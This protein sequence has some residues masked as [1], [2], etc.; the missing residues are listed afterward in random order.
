MRMD[1]NKKHKDNL[2]DH[3]RLCAKKI[4]PNAGYPRP[5]PTSTYEQIFQQHL[6]IFLPEDDEVRK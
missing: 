6:H 1:D 5:K 2:Q 3:C 4:K